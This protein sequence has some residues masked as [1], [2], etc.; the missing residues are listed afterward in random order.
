[1]SDSI[2]D[3]LCTTFGSRWAGGP[4]TAGFLSQVKGPRDWAS[5]GVICMARNGKPILCT[6][7]DGRFLHHLQDFPV[8]VQCSDG[9]LGEVG[10]LA[11][12][13]RQRAGMMLRQGDGVEQR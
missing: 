2:P 6:G 10:E 13:A 3:T 9:F 8:R 5:S 4:S 12:G 11:G 7:L 1:M